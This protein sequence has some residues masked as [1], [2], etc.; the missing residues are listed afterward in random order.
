[1]RKFVSILCILLLLVATS[2]LAVNIHFC[3][4][5]ISSVDFYG[6]SKGCGG[7]C[8]SKG[9]TEKSSIAAKSCCKNIATII[10][11][12]DTTTSGFSF[13]TEQQTVVFVPVVFAYTIQHSFKTELLKGSVTC[14]APPDISA[15][16]YYIL[17]RSLII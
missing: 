8:D 15:Q 11:T 9:A 13:Q 16:P 5:E 6:K 17:Y 3:G 12:D 4:D 10:N 7:S 14:N 1:M 2:N